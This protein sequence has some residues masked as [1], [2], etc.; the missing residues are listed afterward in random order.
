MVLSRKVPL[1]GKG[2]APT[3]FSFLLFLLLWGSGGTVISFALVQEKLARPSVNLHGVF[4]LTPE[5]GWVVGQLGKIFH[6]TDGGKSWEEQRSRKNL[7]LAAVD[8]VDRRHGWVVGEQGVILYSEDGGVTWKE[9]QSGVSYPLFDVKFVD[10]ER[11]WA[12]GHWGTI[13]FTDDGGRHWVE[14]PLSLALEERGPIE[15][16]ALH[17]VIDPGTGEVV[18]KA[19]QLLTKELIAEIAR[20]RISGVRIRED[21]VLNA[22]FFLD[23]AHGWIAGERGLVLR[24]ENGGETW[25]RVALPRPPTK[26]GEA[27]AEEELMTEEELAAFGVVA[28]PPSLYG[29]FFVS[30]LQGWVVGQEGTIARTQDGG[31][32][33]EFQPS[34]T[35]EALY[36]VGIEGDTGWIAGDKGTVL[37]STNGGMRWER[38]ELGL[39]YRLSWLRRLAVVSGDHAFLVGADGLVLASGKSPE[40]GLWVQNP[41]EK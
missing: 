38:K 5:E 19:G 34:E 3:L 22:V 30:P 41:A 26:Q 28:P 33:W 7:L 2:T 36:D 35:R 17:D 16:A 20:R 12:V 13:L 31:H 40:Q 4:F 6:T 11:G 9:Q 1:R 25:E 23:Q 10:R 37:V 21:I 15:P 39:E 18:A 32:Q 14:R 24:T 29:I 8:F 27:A